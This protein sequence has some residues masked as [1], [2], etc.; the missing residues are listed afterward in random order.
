VTLTRQLDLASQ[1]V[2]RARLKPL[3]Q[4]PE[5][6]LCCEPH[7]ERLAKYLDRVLE[8]LPDQSFDADIACP[9]CG[10]ALK[11]V[12]CMSIRRIDAGCWI[13]IACYEFDEGV[14]Q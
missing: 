5:E 8:A 11:A 14:C 7:K 13:P 4:I 9:F 2:V 3:D 6:F 10:R 1:R 12:K